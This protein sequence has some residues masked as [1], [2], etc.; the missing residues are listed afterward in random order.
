MMKEPSFSGDFSR[1]RSNTLRIDL[2]GV[3]WGLMGGKRDWKAVV[4]MDSRCLGTLELASALGSV[5][6]FMTS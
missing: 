2:R 1:L 4:V 5:K 3:F 6:L